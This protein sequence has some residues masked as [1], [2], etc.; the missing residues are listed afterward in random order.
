MTFKKDSLLLRIITYNGVAIVLVSAI[1]ALLFGLI[2]INEINSRL[3]D[4]S[5]EKINIL[6]K[7]YVAIIEKT[8]R[9]LFNAVTT[10]LNLVTLN[11]EETGGV[12]Q[13]KLAEV[14]KNQLNIES[15]SRY[16]KS[17]VQIISTNRTVLSENGAREIKY[18]IIGSDELVPFI[19]TLETKS[20][21]FVGTNNNIYVRI[22]Q[23]YR[24][25]RA[26]EKNYIIL[27]MPLSNFNFERVRDFIDLEFH[28]KIF[29]LS[30]NRYI[31]GE[32][33]IDVEKDFIKNTFK[34]KKNKNLLEYNFYFSDMK[35][36]GEPYYLAMNSL[37]NNNGSVVGNIGIA[38]SK[39]NSQ[40]IK[41]MLATIILA[42]AFLSVVI[43]T[44]LC[45]RIF[46][47]ILNPLSILTEKMQEIGQLGNENT[48][49]EL[50]EETIYEIRA[51]ANS[52]KNLSE[53]ISRNENLLLNKNEKLNSNLN[54]VVAVEKILMALDI[55]KNFTE[56]IGELLKALTSEMGMGYS[57]ALYLE[58][59]KEKNI[60]C[61]KEV[62]INPYISS[63]IEK[64]TKGIDGFSF[65]IKD[66]QNLL[67][68]LKV[69]YETG[70]LFSDSME[71]NK[72]IFY[73]EK[74]YKFNFGNE[75]FKSL[76][77]KN[78]LLFPITDKDIKLGCILVDY[79]GKNRKI[80]EEEVEVMTL[81]L[82]NLIVRVKND[83]QE[84]EK[85][86]NERILTMNKIS[87]RFLDS[88]DKLLNKVETFIEKI[89]N[90]EY[91]SKDIVS[92]NKYIEDRKKQNM[93]M[94]EVLDN[95][96]RNFKAVN[97]EKLLMKI[98]NDHEIIMNKYGINLSLFSDFNGTIYADKKKI[99]QM[100]VE[101]I[102]NSI[103]AITVR[104][105]LDKKINIVLKGEEN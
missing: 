46:I 73:N 96:V 21:Y 66:F 49:I 105:K 12:A 61:A 39:R 98:V 76:G 43:S 88:N 45:A 90:R 102:K 69:K 41:Y 1:M 81:L 104:N 68:L 19:S 77:F 52:I 55:N 93:I 27:T 63:N 34:S 5:R 74:G 86:T 65:Q 84:E 80:S 30:K 13:E 56:S 72:I 57:R 35:V 58:Y 85:L 17:F 83:L 31:A 94:R 38:I 67:P 62:S 26:F 16:N 48:Q 50:E 15:Y 97:L 32:L 8:G 89:I 23:Q 33:N 60:L 100:L 51:I 79:F 42:V 87:N 36:N 44:A 18:D 64:Y 103:E 95:S 82:M 59:D 53:R 78:F 4:K 3:L 22:I 9:E 2:T 92:L 29:I 47:K 24:L 99:Y 54:R 25:N 11:F 71:A 7:A 75:L 28:D 40:V 101:I 37:K 70:N 20:Y 6:D 14:V 91:N 10:A